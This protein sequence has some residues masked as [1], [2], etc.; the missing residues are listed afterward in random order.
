MPLGSVT[1][2]A[3]FDVSPA[4]S[5]TLCADGGSPCPPAIQR[6]HGVAVNATLAA[7]AAASIAQ[8]IHLDDAATRGDGESTFE[9]TAAASAVG[10][11]NEGS[12][13]DP[14]RA[15]AASIAPALSYLRSGSTSSARSTTW[16][17]RSGSSGRSSRS[18]ER[19]RAA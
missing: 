10:A 19:W 2:R 13:A 18:Q 12:D 1:L 9:K 15:S 14:S 6:R 4:R 3:V 8:P 16:T 5:L 11:L 17:K 7:P